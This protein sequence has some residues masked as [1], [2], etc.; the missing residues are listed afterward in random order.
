MK[1]AYCKVCA[2]SVELNTLSPWYALAFQ[3]PEIV[4]I[5]CS[6]ECA[7]EDRQSVPDDRDV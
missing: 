5:Y 4:N 6:P 2:K 7:A 3:H 1:E